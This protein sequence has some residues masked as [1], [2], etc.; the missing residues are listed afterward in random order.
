MA[1][2]ATTFYQLPIWFLPFN[3]IASPIVTCIGALIGFGSLI[4]EFD[5]SMGNTL[6][7][8]GGH[9]AKYAIELLSSFDSSHPLAIQLESGKD[10]I[11]T[12][13]VTMGWL[14]QT[15]IP[16]LLERILSATSVVY[17]T[18]TLLR[19]LVKFQ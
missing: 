12:S 3:V 13:L 14:F 15:T 5:P 2:T 17:A 18:I 8:Y 10:F 6:L 11:G 19:L 1:W 7:I 4:E 9:I 16:T